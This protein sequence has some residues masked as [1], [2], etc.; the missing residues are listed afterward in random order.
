MT[1]KIKLVRSIEYLHTSPTGEV[2][3]ERSKQLLVDLA[4]AKRPPADYDIILD[5][6]RS[7]LKLS[8]T[9]IWYLAA[10]L[11]NH[12]HTFKD[13]VAVLILPGLDFDKAK[14]FELC[15]KNRGLNVE[16]F[17]NYEDAV[18]WLYENEI[19]VSPNN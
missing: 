4:K 12:D 14:F 3:L 11:V 1:T 13:K 19:S 17:T 2:D 18:Q 6:R 8:T 10:D 15:S 9:D 5:F 16:V 7:Q